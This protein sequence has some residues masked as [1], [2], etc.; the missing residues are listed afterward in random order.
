MKALLIPSF[1]FSVAACTAKP[2]VLP[3]G[4]GVCESPFYG[5]DCM[6]TV[7]KMSLFYNGLPCNRC[8][9]K[10]DGDDKGCAWVNQGD[11]TNAPNLWCTRY[12][13]VCSALNADFVKR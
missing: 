4:T 7:G 2:P 6:D 3:T 12:C 5:D 9:I 13:N 1:L 10:G 8:Q 11:V